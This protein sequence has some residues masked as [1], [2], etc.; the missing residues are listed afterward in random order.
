MKITLNYKLKNIIGIH[1]CE[2]HRNLSAD[3]VKSNL[4]FLLIFFLSPNCNFAQSK[5]NDS[6]SFFNNKPIY[7]Y[8]YPNVLSNGKDF[9]TQKKAF[10]KAI[11]ER[12][13][14]NGIVTVY[15]FINEFGETNFYTTQLC[16][17]NYKTLSI[18][19]ELEPL[20]A[21]ILQAVRNTSPWKPMLNDKKEAVNSRKFYSFKFNNGQLIEIL[22]K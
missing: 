22:P 13:N 4:V 15:F 12:T 20:C 1:H 21:Q 16:D 2:E 3:F 7:P 17:L 18:S 9:Y 6:C 5:S 8:Y 14:F 10:K 11:T 19:K